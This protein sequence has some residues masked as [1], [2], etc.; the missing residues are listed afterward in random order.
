MDPHRHFAYLGRGRYAEQLARWFEYVPR[1]RLRIIPSE[2]LYAAPAD[3]VRE[4][5]EW[6]GV[7][8]PVVRTYPV[9]HEGGNPPMNDA[10]RKQLT[11]YFAPHN[12]RLIELLG[13]EFPWA[14][15]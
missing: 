14:A 2:R 13:E 3:V 6:L 9:F 15:P 1:S 4:T 7:G 12:A 10:T 8:A 11:E 5:S